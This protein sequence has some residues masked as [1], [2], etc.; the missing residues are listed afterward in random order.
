MY[1]IKKE[2]GICCN[3]YKKPFNVRTKV[4][5]SF[6]KESNL[7]I[8]CTTMAHFGVK[9]ECCLLLCHHDKLMVGAK[10]NSTLDM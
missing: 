9:Q 2:T 6:G 3:K 5:I 4:L 8:F 10:R 7:D 1:L